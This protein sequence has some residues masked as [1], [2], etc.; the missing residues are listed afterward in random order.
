M[1]HDFGPHGVRCNA[2]APGEIDTSIPSPGTADIVEREIPMKRLGKP[3]EVA[4]LIY[5]LHVAEF[6][7]QR[8]P[9]YTSTAAST[10]DVGHGGA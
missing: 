7:C 1:A 8:G 9:R 3:S 6:L 4:Q 10:S 5:F 2:I